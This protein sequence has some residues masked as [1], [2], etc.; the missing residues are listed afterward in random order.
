MYF[1]AGIQL[2]DIDEIPE[3]SSNKLDEPITT[4]IMLKI[5]ADVIKPI[6][7]RLDDHEKR[8]TAL[9]ENNAV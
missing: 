6:H 1:I 8:I 7:V 5:I 2:S 3:L 4:G 9:E